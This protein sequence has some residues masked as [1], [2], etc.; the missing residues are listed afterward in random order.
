MNRA[1]LHSYIPFLHRLRQVV[2]QNKIDLTIENYSV[3]DTDGTVHEI[4]EVRH[5]RSI[6]LTHHHGASVVL[7][8]HLL[9]HRW[10][11]HNPANNPIVTD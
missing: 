7:L 5:L 2:I 4:E 8:P 1:S 11:V 9:W 6:A 3:V 10:K